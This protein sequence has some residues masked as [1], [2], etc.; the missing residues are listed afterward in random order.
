MSGAPA[1]PAGRRR[2]DVALVRRGLARSRGH[3]REL[4]DA[5]LVRVDG[6]P[7]AK[8][9]ALV[10]EDVELGLTVTPQGWVGRGAA[11]LSA[12]VTRFAIPVTGRRC[13]DVGASTGGF[14]QVLLLAGAEHVIA[15]DVGRG[16][17]APILHADPRV[18]DLA[19]RDI[20]GTDP[21]VLGRFD[22]VVVDLSFISVT[23]VA[24]HLARL[25][26]DDGDLVVLVKP[27]FEVGRGRV[28]KGGVVRSAASRRDAVLRVCRAL[29]D[30]GIG[31][32]GIAPSPMSGAAG[33]R[34]Y[35]VWGSTRQ[36]GRLAWSQVQA[37]IGETEASE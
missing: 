34:E 22:L 18:T 31:V 6:G 16:Q 25:L 23:L 11:K 12:A 20:R 8:A 15:L 3:A 17:L 7:A 29:A 28:G 24:G 27:Q 10:A 4:I 1:G 37:Q 35:L 2:L 14:T 36:D 21:A 33:N 19:G 13:L 5:G 26:E 9:G 32:L 30:E